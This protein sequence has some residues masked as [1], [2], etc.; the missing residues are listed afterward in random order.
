LSA[1]RTNGVIAD[2]HP[3]KQ[4][5]GQCELDRRLGESDGPGDVGEIF[6]GAQRRIEDDPTVDEC[7]F[8]LTRVHR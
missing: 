7:E 5:A 1:A 6:P 8:E 2:A 3:R 4:L